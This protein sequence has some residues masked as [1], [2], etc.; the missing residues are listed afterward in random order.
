MRRELRLKGWLIT[1]NTV[2]SRFGPPGGRGRHS[3]S[4]WSQAK[5]ECDLKLGYPIK[6]ATTSE[7]SR[8]PNLHDGP[9][10]YSSEGRTAHFRRLDVLERLNAVFAMIR[11][12][13]R[14]NVG[15]VRP[16]APLQLVATIAYF[17]CRVPSSL[18]TYT[19]ISVIGMDICAVADRI[20]GQ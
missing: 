18:T 9:G 5:L 1:I 12:S 17:A 8:T 2:L 13:I 20:V 4:A 11:R 6:P 3:S 10:C 19:A 14:L 16:C 15:W 7:H